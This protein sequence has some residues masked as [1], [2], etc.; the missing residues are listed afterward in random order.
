MA[1]RSICRRPSASRKC[2]ALPWHCGFGTPQLFP[3]PFA[4]WKSR[5]I[6]TPAAPPPFRSTARPQH[7][8]PTRASPYLPFRS[9]DWWPARRSTPGP[10]RRPEPGRAR[11]IHVRSRFHRD[12]DSPGATTCALGPWTTTASPS[13]RPNPRP[14]QASPPSEPP[15]CRR[16]ARAPRNVEGVDKEI[17]P[18]GH[19][20]RARPTC[21][22]ALGEFQ[23]GAFAVRFHP[24]QNDAISLHA[25][26]RLGT[27]LAGGRRK[28]LNFSGADES[29]AECV[30]CARIAKRA[31]HETTAMVK[32]TE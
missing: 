15:R 9:W 19:G 14:I 28:G 12:A 8:I 7:R 20:L 24:A 29:A 32:R 22:S 21:W 27:V 10:A 5:S 1:A 2:P 13:E 30:R 4:P 11:R 3:P 25:K 16:R 23:R 31:K 18:R 17:R 6:R 26:L